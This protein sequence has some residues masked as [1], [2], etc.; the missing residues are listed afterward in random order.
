LVED[1]SP[2]RHDMLIAAC[3]PERYASLGV[4]GGHASCADNLLTAL[5]AFTADPPAVPQ[6][7][8]VFMHIPV[9]EHGGLRWLPAVSAAG[10]SVTFRAEMDCVV[11]VSACPQDI[12]GI[13]GGMPTALAVDVLESAPAKPARS[14]PPHAA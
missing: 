4:A 8:N 2:G 13:N 7:I 3:D 9:D 1:A 6:P 11:V 12:V 10:D 14:A 5:A